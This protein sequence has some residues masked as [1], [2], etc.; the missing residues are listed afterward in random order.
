MRDV[1]SL[2]TRTLRKYRG[3][4]LVGVGLV[5]VAALSIWL[6]K[7]EPAWIQGQIEVTRVR[8]AA[9][10]PGR[11]ESILVHEGESVAA[12]QRVAVLA[13]PEIG[14]KARQADALVE[15]AEAQADKA[16]AG[17]RKEQIQI[18]RAQW[19]AA[20]DQAVLAETTRGRMQRLFDD[21]VIPA[22]KRD[23]ATARAQAAR[24]QTD[25]ARQ[26]YLIAQNA[27]RPEDLRSARA[28]VAQAMGGR[29]E[30]QAALDELHLV[31]PVEGEVT[32]RV[33]EPGE[34]VAAGAPVLVIARLR[35]MW[36]TL[37]LREDLLSRVRMGSRLNG[38]IPALGNREVVFVID[39]I[40]PLADFATWRS[41]RDLGGFD[42]RT[43]EVRARPTATVPGLRPGMSVLIAEQAL[44]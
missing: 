2:F 19:K 6:L 7:P 12:G 27:T 29:A 25:A 16:R 32:T 10:V 5:A 4:I 35:D 33:A 44:R 22:Q 1:M 23:E 37:N 36:L 8:I 28:Q 20:E 43:F 18:A 14:A 9:K 3:A 34:V 21:G 30:V 41:T 38:R 13:I 24:A 26:A 39:Y 40:A 17:A 15:S 42:L 31:S 11:V